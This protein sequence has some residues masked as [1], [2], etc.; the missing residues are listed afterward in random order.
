MHVFFFYIF[1]CVFLLLLL[2]H[3]CLCAWACVCVCLWACS[4][5]SGTN[6]TVN[7]AKRRCSIIWRSS[8]NV[9]AHVSSRHGV[10]HVDESS[11]DRVIA[12]PMLCIRVSEQSRAIDASA[13]LSRRDWRKAGRSTQTLEARIR[14]Q[15][16]LH[17]DAGLHCQIVGRGSSSL[18]LVT[19]RH[20]KSVRFKHNQ[21]LCSIKSSAI[22][23]HFGTKG[24]GKIMERVELEV[25]NH[26]DKIGQPNKDRLSCPAS[27]SGM[28][29]KGTLFF[30]PLHSTLQKE[31]KCILRTIQTW[32]S[33]F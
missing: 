13:T 24:R 20:W 15:G 10:Y 30:L 19:T 27:S 4:L 16:I 6:G 28:T 29:A 14:S 25:I 5:V 3:L 31:N 23:T 2:F 26:V 12:F 11:R 21:T 33:Y 8:M 22:C 17:S 18:N 9:T 7:E 1:C 32:L